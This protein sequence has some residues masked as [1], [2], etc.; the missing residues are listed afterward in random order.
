MNTPCS[1]DGPTFDSQVIPLTFCDVCGR[2]WDTDPAGLATVADLADTPAP[3]HDPEERDRQAVAEVV[4][5][6][7]TRPAAPA[8]VPE[9]IDS[10][11]P[12]A[13]ELN[14]AHLLDDVTLYRY[15]PPA[16]VCEH[17]ATLTFRAGVMGGHPVTFD[18][19]LYYCLVCH[20]LAPTQEETPTP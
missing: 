15:E 13:A 3:A 16:E 1:C 8:F 6:W 12:T 9:P 19:P 14:A 18:T 10:L 20:H 2:P 17:G 7:D 5:G 4:A 11:A